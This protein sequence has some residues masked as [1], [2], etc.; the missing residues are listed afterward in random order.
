MPRV[1]RRAPVVGDNWEDEDPK[2]HYHV[3]GDKDT[4]NGP[5]H[6]VV[7]LKPPYDAFYP[8]PH[9]SGTSVGSRYMKDVPEETQGQLF[10]YDHEPPKISYLTSTSPAHMLPLLGLA[11]IESKARFGEHPAPDSSLSMHSAPIAK[12]LKDKGVIP[13]HVTVR[14]KSNGMSMD[15]AEDD[16]WDAVQE[17]GR[18]DWGSHNDTGLGREQPSFRYRHGGTYMRQAIRNAKPETPS[19]GAQFQQDTLF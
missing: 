17:L 15:N 10:E 9:Y 3:F 19:K 7:H 5:S 14:E 13:N 16:K 2:T 11:S 12:S 8:S 18:H 4:G 1:F 6:G